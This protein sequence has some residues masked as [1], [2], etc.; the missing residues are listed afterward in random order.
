MD[1][2]TLSGNEF[3]ALASETR[4]S[5]IKLLQ[6]RNHTLSELS[7]K[8]SLAA[9]TIKQHLGILENAGLIEQVDEGRKWKYYCLTK[10]G[11]KILCNEEQKNILIVLAAS[12][13]GLAVTLYSFLGMFW[14]AQILR[15]GMPIQSEQAGKALDTV[16]SGICN[17]IQKAAAATQ[18][19]A[20]PFEK[21]VILAVLL[22]ALSILIGFLIAKAK[23][24]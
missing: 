19:L 3:K 24:K 23:K 6:Q 14:Q 10:K 2:I 15:L 16:S 5:L 20:V 18:P 4:V 21:A 17:E 12:I 8:T 13:L 11:K 1:F 22:V 9:P 7:Q